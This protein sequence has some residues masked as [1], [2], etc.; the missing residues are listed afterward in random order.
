MLT[1]EG[2]VC[3]W[4]GGE[5]DPHDPHREIGD[6][7]GVCGVQMVLHRACFEAWPGRADRS[8]HR[9]GQVREH[10][11]A[12]AWQAVVLDDDHA[13][14]VAHLDW[15]LDAA[16]PGTLCSVSVWL[17]VS[18]E[19]VEV[20]SDEWDSWVAA[21]EVPTLDLARFE[22]AALADVRSRLREELPT[23]DSIAAAIDWH[24]K[25]AL[26]REHHAREDE[27]RRGEHERRVAARGHWERVAQQIQTVG[28]E[29]PHCRVQP[30]A[31]R[32]FDR[33]L[34]GSFFICMNCHRSITPTAEWPPPRPSRPAS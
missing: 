15:G 11:V 7:C 26:A 32:S 13:L 6:D 17:A 33:G 9:V 27:A 16:G 25:S 5:I 2:P 30:H 21:A 23:R 19:C 3:R 31:Y 28:L 8:R 18:G 12:S 1:A 14:V 4:C 10:A 24:T 34:D 22:L 29:C 20:P